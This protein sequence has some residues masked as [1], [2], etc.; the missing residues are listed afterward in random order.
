MIA[1]PWLFALL[2]LTGYVFLSGWWR[3]DPSTTGTTLPRNLGCACG[4]YAVVGDDIRLWTGDTGW[5]HSR[6]MCCPA[7]EVVR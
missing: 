5:M 7:V 3:D 4:T 6:A 2:I 1:W